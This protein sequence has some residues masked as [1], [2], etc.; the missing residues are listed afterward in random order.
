MREFAT[1]RKLEFNANKTQLICFHLPHMHPQSATI[2]FNNVA[3]QYSSKVT[4][5]GHI[6]TSTLDDY[7]DIARVFKDLIRK[8]YSVLCFIMWILL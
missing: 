3:L 7:E 2:L 6:L 4:H 1:K 8:A 5:L